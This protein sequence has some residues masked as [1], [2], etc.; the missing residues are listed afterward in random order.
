[1]Y[2]HAHWLEASIKQKQ[3]EGAVPNKC[4]HDRTRE[5]SIDGWNCNGGCSDA[6]L[7]DADEKKSKVVKEGIMNE[8][9][10]TFY[11][12]VVLKMTLAHE[13]VICIQ[14]GK[15]ASCWTQK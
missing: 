8:P 9:V 1:M 4:G 14:F 5:C 2:V 13:Y 11:N 6:E 15:I 3:E 10:L 12:T 7:S